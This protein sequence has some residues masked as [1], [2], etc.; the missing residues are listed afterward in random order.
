MA[1]SICDLKTNEHG[2]EM[3]LHGSA[4]LPAACYHDDITQAPVRWHWHDEFEVI[5]VTEG[6][7]DIVVGS[8]KYTTRKGDGVFINA[9]V[10][11][12][13]QNTGTS[14]CHLISIVFHPRLIGGSPDSIYWKKYL[15]PILTD[16][17]FHGFFL[18]HNIPWQKDFL[19]SL[20]TAWHA[21]A[22][23]GP[24]Y[25][26]LVREQ[27]SHMIYLFMSYHHINAGHFSEK[28]L[29]NNER[30]KT[31]LQFIQS[32]FGD[33]LDISQ[34][35][36][37]ASISTSECL[38]CFRDTIGMTPI[39][40][41]KQYRIQ[42]AAELLDNSTAKIADIAHRCGFQEMSYF[43]KTFRQITNYTPSAY[44]KRETS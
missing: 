37:A 35:A 4:L 22:Q 1:I 11:H 42:Q 43:A 33:N 44:R 7:M 25:E 10:L 23:E 32:N 2:R 3:I 30:I 8:E 36:G 29:R 21:L 40:Y 12:S 15:N 34:I 20:E 28:S 17:S 39:Q 13:A 14:S 38:R 27:L 41:L 26:F 9:A 31:M 24:G 18:N 5:L 19:D 6:E 16:S